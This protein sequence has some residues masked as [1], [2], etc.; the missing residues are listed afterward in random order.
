MPRCS[1]AVFPRLFLPAFLI[2]FLTACGSGSGGNS[3]LPPPPVNQF[4]HVYVAFPPKSG[5]NNTHFMNTVMNQAAIEGVTEPNVWSSIETGT[6]G[7]AT[8]SPVGT[9]VCQI[10]SS[11]WTHTYNWSQTDADNL[12]WFQAQGGTKKVNILL[13]GINSVASTCLITNDCINVSTPYYVTSPGW[14]THAAP[15][16]Q[17]LING[18]KDGCTMWIGLIVSSMTRNSSGLVTVVDNDHG[19]KN[20]D[21]IWIGNTTPSNFNIQVA[22]VTSVQVVS[23]TQKLT[24]TAANSF[25]VGMKVTFLK[26]GNATFLNGQTV[27]VTSSSS[28]QF[29]ATFAHADYGPS[30]ETTGVAEPDGVPVQNATANTFQYQSGTLSA[31]TASVPGT[32]ISSQQSWPVPYE[33]S[34]K[35]AWEAFIAAAIIHFN[36]SPNRSQITYMR[37]GRSAG[38]EAFPYCTDTLE[39]LP[40]ENAYTKAGWLQYYTDIDNFIQQQNPQIQMLDPLNEAGQPVDNTYGSAEAQIAVS[41][42]NAAGKIN[43]FGSQGLRATDI[44][45]YAQSADDC[46]SD[47]CAMFNTYYTAG[48]PLEL[49]QIDLSDP[50][51]SINPASE[52]GDLRPLL[53][54]AVQRHMTILELYSFD[55]LLAYDPNYCVL[56]TPD[57]GT[58]GAGSIEIPVTVLPPQDQNPYF[59][60]VGQPGQTGA[61][62]DGSYAT[63]I[64][65]TEGAH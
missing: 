47:W 11:G 30:S 21:L 56:A 15:N 42:Q 65:Q 27:T 38:G 28:T 53:P 63:V 36:N 62:G 60:L 29:T 5:T 33:P 45:N 19:Y 10:D 35:T 55:A 25:P 49:Q 1:G 6:P 37:I 44:P 24:I 46:T 64:N 31:G 13:D 2:L 51:A 14:V 3:K 34:Y 48:Y 9:D 57:N 16:G 20:G 43:G 12:V 41:H 26:L 23:S 58:C 8:C 54:F 32:I 4:T 40:G 59:Q 61:K 18:N 52:T 7:V 22:D 50:T 17:D 39:D